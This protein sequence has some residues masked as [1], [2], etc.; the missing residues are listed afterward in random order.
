MTDRAHLDFCLALHR[1]AAP[2][3]GRNAC[4]SPFSVA[5]ALGLVATGARG[6]TRDELTA[7][8]GSEVD[9]LAMLLADAATLQA[10]GSRDDDP[11]LAVANTLWADST[12]DIRDEFA[13]E[14]IRWSGGAVRDAPFSSAPEKARDLINAD[15]ADTTHELI[16]ELLPAG[17]HPGRHG[18]RAG[19]RALPEG[20]LEA[21]LRRGADGP[22]PFHSPAG[23]TDVPTMRLAERVGYAHTDGWQVVSLPA[24]GG[25]EALVLLPD[26]RLEAAEPGL[27]TDRLTAL[28]AAVHAHARAAVVAPAARDD[29]VRPSAGLQALGVRTVFTDNADLSGISTS[30]LAV[31]AVLHEAVLSWTSRG[32]EGAAATAVTMRLL[33]MPSG[34]RSRCGSTGRSCCSC[35]TRRPARC[36]SSPGLSRLPELSRHTRHTRHARMRRQ[37]HG[38]DR[39]GIHSGRGLLLKVIYRFARKRSA[40]CRSRSP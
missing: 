15:V 26:E 4:W 36:T 14:L 2:D 11:T 25:V 7:L 23:T 10:K 9:D 13:G 5:S 1:V 30:A 24:V 32:M 39:W 18:V 16:P 6:A 17:A 19:Q 31:Q 33:S 27:D 40:P 28:L 29:A 20:R 34:D 21:P 35:G 3:P 8:L 37:G 38:P 22:Q 12:I